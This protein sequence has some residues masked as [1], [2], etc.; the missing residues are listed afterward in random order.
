MAS[1]LKK[2]LE[3]HGHDGPD[4]VGAFH[5][6]LII[7]DRALCIGEA[8]QVLYRSNKLNP[9]TL[10][11]EGW[12]EY[13]HDHSR[14]VRAH[15]CDRA[16]AS[17][18]GKLAV[19]PAWLAGAKELTWLGKCLGYSYRDDDGRHEV[20][21]TEPLPELYCTPNGRALLIIQSKRT[22]LA[23][24]WGGRLGVEDRGIVH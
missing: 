24:M 9:T 16:A 4:K 3:F 15:R 21:A 22:L 5:R 23:M 14:G 12:V 11:D 8:T 2:Y 20:K 6:E 10:E 18:P 17:L 7:P 13:F 19:V 1:A